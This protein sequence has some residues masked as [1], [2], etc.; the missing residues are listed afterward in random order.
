MTWW[1][2]PKPDTPAPYEK[3]TT[4]PPSSTHR[5]RGASTTT[6]SAASPTG[7]GGRIPRGATDL[8]GRLLRSRGDPGSDVQAIYA[9][10]PRA[11]LLAPDDFPV[12]GPDQFTAAPFGYRNVRR[13]DIA[14][15]S[16]EEIVDCRGQR[17]Y[18]AQ[19]SG[20]LV[21]QRRGD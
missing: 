18:T 17:V 21:D 12:R 13:G 16:G 15:F 5:A 2:A 3:P 11:L 4:R 6:T 7:T 20:G 9:C 8:D 1:P 10:L 14:N 19:Y